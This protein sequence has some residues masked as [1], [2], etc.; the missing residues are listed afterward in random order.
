[1]RSYE[2]FRHLL[3][4]YIEGSISHVEIDEFF[5]LVA[6]GDYDDIIKDNFDKTILEP[7]DQLIPDLPQGISHNLIRKILVKDE[8]HSKQTRVIFLEKKWLVAAS[9]F[10]FFALPLYLLV[11]KNNQD[12]FVSAFVNNSTQKILN[13]T[14]QQLALLLPDGS[15]VVLQPKSSLFYSKNQF[16]NKREVY[17]EGEAS[18]NI[19]KDHLKP[20]YVY[21]NKLVTKV[22]GTS[23][24]IK[25]NQLTGNVEVAVL[26]GKVQVYENEKI[27]NGKLQKTSLIITPNQKAIFETDKLFFE[28]TLVDKPEPIT[29][30]D[31]ESA[32]KQI[33]VK[34]VAFNFENTKLSEV[35]KK[36]EDAYGIEIIVN[37]EDIYNCVFSGDITKQELF[38]KLKII[39]LA[40]NS[41]YE[42][43]GTKIL[44]NGGGC[45]N[46]NQ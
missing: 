40:T 39:S 42:V 27:L 26:T 14:K 2:R 38:N 8:R 36:L 33:Q 30:I 9:L 44:I 13:K 16:A 18:F 10:L 25:T 11:I 3:N 31:D 7:D 34:P 19:A 37:N 21:Y 1:M 15:R 43:N 23:F 4:L 12:K 28:T 20:F 41:T 45:K 22:L 29:E 46:T 24:N 5:E 6:T 32:K 35:L 17:M